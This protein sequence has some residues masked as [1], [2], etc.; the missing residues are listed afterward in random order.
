MSNLQ[1]YIHPDAKIGKNVTISPFSYIYGDV[2][3]GDN[4]WIGPNVTIMDGARIGKN[5]KIFPGAVISAAPQD[6]KFA[7]EITT[8]EIG[9]NT[10]IREYASIHRGTVDKMKT[11][12]G[13][14]CLIMGYVHVAH[15]CIIGNNCIL[16]NY[17]GLSGHTTVDDW[18]ILEGKVGTQQFIHIG[19]HAFIA[20]ATLV[21]KNVPP[22]VK[23]ARE[24]ISYMGVNVI[25]M[26]RRGISDAD[27]LEIQNIYRVMFQKGLNITQALEIIDKEFEDG[28]KRNMIVDFVKASDKGIINRG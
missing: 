14:N 7:G 4:T 6:L 5:V 3:I 20:G 13:Q 27:I 9:D 8:T 10:V 2:E 11:A 17:T 26:R 21:R 18:A 25:G 12:I 28:D 15:D 22:F 16:A 23:A 24:P 1:A 19:A